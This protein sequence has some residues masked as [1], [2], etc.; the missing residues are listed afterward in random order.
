MSLIFVAV[1]DDQRALSL[2]G[3]C[4]GGGVHERFESGMIAQGGE[5]GIVLHPLT[6]SPTSRGGFLQTVKRFL[7]MTEQSVNASDVV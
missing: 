3:Q 7:G 2:C 6:L 1:A 5:I 4:I